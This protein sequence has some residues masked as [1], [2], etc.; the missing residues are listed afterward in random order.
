MNS[1]SQNIN[2]LP[3]PGPD[4]VE[5]HEG[6]SGTHFESRSLNVRSL[7]LRSLAKLVQLYWSLF[8]FAA[9]PGRYPPYPPPARG[10]LARRRCLR[11]SKSAIEGASLDVPW[12]PVTCWEAGASPDLILPPRA[13]KATT[14]SATLSSPRPRF[15]RRPACISIRSWCCTV[16]VLAHDVSINTA[17]P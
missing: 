15:A 3:I 2:G 5:P 16:M 4:S 1:A 7:Q 13:P 10:A 12:I 6:L 9:P 11:E 8:R 14:E 17:G